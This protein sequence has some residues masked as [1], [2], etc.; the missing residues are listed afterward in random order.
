MSCEQ[1]A[2]MSVW[3]HGESVARYYADLHAHVTTGR[4]L[5]YEWRLPS[6][7]EESPDLLDLLL[8]FDTAQAYQIFHDCGKPYCLT[9]DEEGKRHFPNH[10]AMSERIWRS[11]SMDEQIARLIG[12]DMDIHLLKAD[13]ILE[14]ANRPEAATL[15]LTG[16]AE[17]HANASMFGGIDSPSF[18]IKFKQ[19]ERRGR[20]ICK[21]W[22]DGLTVPEHEKEGPYNVG[23]SKETGSLTCWG[24]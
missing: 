8:P 19:I 4:P 16:L 12:M 7:L 2:G 9:I 15:L 14:F 10:A 23:S 21:L 11:V 24:V 5:Q 1:T 6:W 20:A 17:I 18:K 13:G 3:E 22:D